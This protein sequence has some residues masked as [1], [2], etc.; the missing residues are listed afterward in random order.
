MQ[1]LK[2]ERTDS[3]HGGRLAC[4]LLSGARD[5]R[6][7]DEGVE[8][9]YGGSLDSWRFFIIGVGRGIDRTVE[10]T[11]KDKPELWGDLPV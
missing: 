11:E 8:L 1:V 9:S 3:R 5:W 4:W 6:G 10:L 2:Q 7:V